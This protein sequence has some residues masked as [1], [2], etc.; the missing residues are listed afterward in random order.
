MRKIIFDS[1]AKGFPADENFLLA[2]DEHREALMS[3]CKGLL[4]D[5]AVILS[6][7][8]INRTGGSNPTTVIKPGCLWAFDMLLFAQEQVFEGDVS[9]SHIWISYQTK[10]ITSVYYSGEEL[11]AYNVTS[12]LIVANKTI[13]LSMGGFKR[14]RDIERLDDWFTNWSVVHRT[15]EL[16]ASISVART[17]G[18]INLRGVAE[19]PFSVSVDRWVSLGNVFRST[20]IT[21]PEGTRD[22][23]AYCA[24]EKLPQDGGEVENSFTDYVGVLKINRQGDLSIRVSR[25]YGNEQSFVGNVIAHIFLTFNVF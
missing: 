7:L 23:F 8:E 13:D 12:A 25:A 11:P 3:L 17:L 2:T 21:L 6:G 10:P 15:E 22:L 18:N 16:N 14:Y 24:I 19:M 5:R 9:E 20:G 4:G 1:V